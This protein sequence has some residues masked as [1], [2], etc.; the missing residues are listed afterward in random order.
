MERDRPRR[1]INATPGPTSSEPPAANANAPPG[2]SCRRPTPSRCRC[3]SPNSRTSSLPARTPRW[4]SMGGPPCRRCAR[5]PRQDHPRSPAALRP[6]TQSDGERPGRPARQQP[7]GRRGRRLRRHCRTILRRLA[8][9]ENGSRRVGQIVERSWAKVN[10][11]SVAMSDG[12][13]RLS[14]QRSCRDPRLA[15]RRSHA[16]EPFAAGAV[17]LRSRGRR[18]RI[19]L[20]QVCP[21]AAASKPRFRPGGRPRKRGGRSLTLGLTKSKSISASY[22]IIEAEQFGVAVTEHKVHKVCFCIVQNTIFQ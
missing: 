15:R 17:W 3:I 10:F 5:H 2:S 16:P 21:D 20:R 6:G 4:F 8:L 13:V 9:L 7:G 1:A 11:V 22:R 19:D 18:R 12:S 14:R